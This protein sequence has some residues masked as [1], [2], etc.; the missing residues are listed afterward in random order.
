M[1]TDLNSELL[2][3]V[4]DEDID[5]VKQHLQNGANVNSISHKEDTPLLVAIETMNIGLITLLLAQGANPNPDPESVYTLPL[6]AAVDIAV[7]A[8][9]NDEAEVM[10]N[11]VVELLVSHGANPTA[12]DKDG[13]SAVEFSLNYNSVAKRFF[14]SLSTK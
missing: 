3:A 11:E 2:K 4:F 10:S 6:N 13:Q 7:Q 9:L 12:K 1:T 8:V 14:D 5:S